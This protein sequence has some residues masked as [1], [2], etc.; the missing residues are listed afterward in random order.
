MRQEFYVNKRVSEYSR[1]SA[2]AVMELVHS[3]ESGLSYEEAERNRHEY[4]SNEGV[5]YQNDSV[6]Y[7]LKKSFINPFSIVLLILAVISFLTE[8][9]L[10]DN[11]KTSLSSV[12]IILSMLL[13]SGLV[14]FTQEMKAGTVAENLIRL[15]NT[16]I[17]VKREGIWESF[18]AEELVVGDL[19]RLYAGD[20][21]PAD[22]RIIRAK[23]CFVSQSVITGESSMMEKKACRLENCPEKLSDYVNTL[24]MGSSVIGGTCEGVVLATGDKTVYGKT[25]VIQDPVKRGFDRGAN[26]IAWVLIRFMVTLVPVVFVAAGLTKGN[27]ISAF[28]FAL[29]VAVGLTPELLPMVIN[30][31]LAKGSRNMGEKDTIV[32]NINA[33]QGFGSIDVL[34]TDKTGTLTSDRLILEYYMDVFGNESEKVLDYGFLNSFYNSGIENPLDL[35]IKKIRDFPE[36]SS[37]FRKLEE[38][39]EKL[40]EL[41]FD[42]GRKASS[43]LVQKKEE[44]LLIMKGDVF[45]VLRH[46]SH[47]RSGSE[48]YAIGQDGEKNVHLIVDEMLEEGMKVLAVASKPFSGNLLKDSDE[49]GLVLDGYIAFFDAPK[50]SGATALKKL[51][52][53][54]V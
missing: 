1:I 28:I 5:A 49:E 20:R 36:T 15:I 37:H 43:V 12:V 39:Y 30:A 10:P 38:E 33:M 23:D 50:K 6:F 40:D 21:V 45:T 34:C 19:V 48:L 18:S 16:T 14:R 2:E 24:F 44:K 3:S 32:K 7:R 11:F 31:C 25:A 22:M 9:L 13:V 47:I 54:N 8:V 41:P 26:S 29:S 46:C 42:Y 17:K 4:G 27:W 52:S 35:A 53:L 51:S